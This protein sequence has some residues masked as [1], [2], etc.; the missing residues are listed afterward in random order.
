MEIAVAYLQEQME[1][2]RFDKRMLEINLKNGS[3]TETDYNTH[4]AKLNDMEAMSEKL[5]LDD[6]SSAATASEPMPE[7]APVVNNNPFEATTAE[8]SVSNTPTNNDPFGSGF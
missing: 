5:V 2:L 6:S 7:P 8:A 1:I 3:L 4:L